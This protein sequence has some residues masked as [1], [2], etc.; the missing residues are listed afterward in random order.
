VTHLKIGIFSNSNYR[1]TFAHIVR[2]KMQLLVFQ[3][4]LLVVQQRLRYHCVLHFSLADRV[5]RFQT[6]LLCICMLLMV[7]LHF[8]YGMRIGVYSGY[9]YHGHRLHQVARSLLGSLLVRKKIHFR[10]NHF[11]IYKCKQLM[12][13]CTVHW[14]SKDC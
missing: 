5:F 11:Y 2:Y 3:V 8:R 12:L 4:E 6:I 10:N 13:D 1:V 14:L 9:T 7:C